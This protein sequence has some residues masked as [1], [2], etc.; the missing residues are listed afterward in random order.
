MKIIGISPY[1]EKCYLCIVMA[2]IGVMDSGSGGLSVLREL[3]RVLPEEEYLYFSDN[4]Y[5]PYGEKS[6]E[7]ILGRCRAIVE[8]FLSQGARGVVIA[9]NTATAAAI[10][11]LRAEYPHIPFVGMEPAIKPAVLSTRSG[12]IG[13]LATE[14]T[15]HSEKYL[16][17]RERYSQGVRVVEHVGEGFVELVESMDLHSS[18]TSEVVERSLTPLLEQGADTIVLGCTHY[19]FLIP[20]MQEIAGPDVNFIDPAPA[21]A[22]QLAR[23][24]QAEGILTGEGPGCV[25]LKSSG[26]TNPVRRLYEFITA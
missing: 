2:K 25:K 17:T 18:H 11:T 14:S 15:L 24:L 12:T 21:A 10:A 9:C 23:V 5:C 4:A 13:V 22:R 6:R 3:L 26:P 16:D 1:G 20:V 7:F 19:P 8:D